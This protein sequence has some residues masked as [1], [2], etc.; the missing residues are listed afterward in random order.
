MEIIVVVTIIM[1]LAGSSVFVYQSVLENSKESRALMDVKNIEKAVE[2]FNLRYGNYPPTI[3]M[4]CDRQ[5]DG[6]TALLDERVIIDPWG[7]HYIFEPGNV[8]A[9]TGKPH[10]YSNGPPGKGKILGNWPG[11]G[12]K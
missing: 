5:Q 6:S 12:S 4:L 9:R 10:V 3:E 8:H 7:Q 2:V 1:I 11:E